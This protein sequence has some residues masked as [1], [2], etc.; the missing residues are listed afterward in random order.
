[1]STRSC[2]SRTRSHLPAASSTVSRLDR[3]RD[4]HERVDLAVAEN[5]DTPCVMNAWCMLSCAA[6]CAELGLDAEARR[7]ED[8]ANALGMEGY[9][10]WLDP[11]RARLV[12]VRG[13]L[14]A[15]GGMI[16]GSHKWPWVTW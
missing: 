8:A 15:L 13:D 1:R 7:L 4:M 12:M 2:M 14:D 11:P 5:V 3:V 10:L 16:E 6:A 9:D